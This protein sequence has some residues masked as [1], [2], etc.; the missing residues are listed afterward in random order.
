MKHSSGRT[1]SGLRILVL[2]LLAVMSY[3]LG[4]DAGF[5][6][7]D[8]RTRQQQVWEAA[9]RVNRDCQ[10]CGD[11]EDDGAPA[12]ATAITTTGN[13]AE[14]DLDQLASGPPHGIVLAPPVALTG[15][16]H[17]GAAR[18]SQ[19]PPTPRAGALGIEPKS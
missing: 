16:A 14:I 11:G 7:G 17:F 13:P 12:I 8:W 5:T 4:Y 2:L 18:V 10:Q 1:A 3:Q 6:K 19:A 9:G 15:K